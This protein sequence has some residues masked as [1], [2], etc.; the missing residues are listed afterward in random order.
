M[1]KYVNDVVKTKANVLQDLFALCPFTL[2]QIILKQP[3]LSDENGNQ[4][5]E[6]WSMGTPSWIHSTWLKTNQTSSSHG[7]E[8][9][10]V[11]LFLHVLTSS[12]SGIRQSSAPQR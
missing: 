11:Q 7:P 10:N 3:C 6:T 1:F 4:V 5:P 8:L 12:V 2:P 9:R